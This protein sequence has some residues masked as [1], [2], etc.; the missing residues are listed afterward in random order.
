MPSKE[1]KRSGVP[2]GGATT[3]RNS[4]SPLRAFLCHSSQDSEFVIEVAKH[5]MRNFDEVFY[6]E[7]YQRANVP[8][9]ETINE[10][11]AR[12]PIFIVFLGKELTKWQR[13]EIATAQALHNKGQTRRLFLVRIAR[14]GS[15]ST[16]PKVCSTMNH[17]FGIDVRTTSLE[18]AENVANRIFQ[19]VVKAPTPPL[20]DHYQWRSID[21]LPLNPHLFSYEKDIIDFFK[22]KIRYGA[23]LHEKEPEAGTAGAQSERG[24][25]R[26][27]R[28]EIR[29]K[30]LQGCPTEWPDVELCKW[31]SSREVHEGLKENDVGKPRPPEARVVTAAL[32][33]Q[34]SHSDAEPRPDGMKLSGLLSFPEAGPRSQ[35][36]FP[37]PNQ[38]ELKVAILVSGGIAPGINAV[39]DGITQRHWLYATRGNY[40]GFLEIHGLQNGFLAFDDLDKSMIPLT[41][42]TTSD[43]VNEGG[44]IIGTSRAEVLIDANR[45]IN[46]L[47]Q[48][49]NQLS[50][51]RIDILYIIGG[52]GSMRAAHALWNIARKGKVTDPHPLSVVAIPKTMD[53]DI[54][55]VWQT[56]GFLSAVEKAR[57]IVEHLSTE[58]RSN[59]R[60]CVVQLFGSDSGFVVSHAVLASGTGRCD[61]ALIPENP[62][63]M[64]SIAEHLMTRMC[65]KQQ[66]IPFGLV[67]MAETA[68]PTDALDYLGPPDGDPQLDVGLSKEEKEEIRRFDRLRKMGGRIQGQTDDL[69]RSAGLKIVSRG[70]YKLLH[71]RK[72]KTRK[73]FNVQ[74]EWEKL[75]FFTNE[76][77]HVLR[78][79]PP[80]CSDIIIGHRLGTLAVDNA[81]AG[82]ADFMI[83]QWLTEYV[84][85]PLKLVVLG[86]KRIP[87]SGIFWKSVLAKTGQP[88]S[89]E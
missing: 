14:K 62:F 77:R 25:Y 10:F 11:N 46:N 57:E 8:F 45:R 76:P 53:N 49:Y 74:P 40:V 78:A 7:D 71:G 80:S 27:T 54:L 44:S 6:Y 15:F 60:L 83:S 3:R 63:S 5:L 28:E 2:A 20:P 72:I 1:T 35:L 64:K 22:D 79:I 68:I 69:L 37:H 65:E 61:L 84:L 85:V 23:K 70:L 13:E 4:P 47:L 12:S 21:D 87:G 33:S 18:D 73:Q 59:P 75:R 58:V 51:K 81:M 48:I 26:Y 32:I 43:H 89:L 88:S 66:R 38:R 52:D 29:E 31:H 86:R 34:L 67:V 17:W 24:M 41:P 16:I 42:A 50:T 56:F 82:Y 30:I 19:E 55:W 9:T 39:I 36:L